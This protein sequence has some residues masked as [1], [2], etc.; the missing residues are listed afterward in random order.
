IEQKPCA[1]AI[2]DIGFHLIERESA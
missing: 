2:V 1:E